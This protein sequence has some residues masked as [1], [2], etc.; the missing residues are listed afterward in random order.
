MLWKL[1]IVAILATST[2]AHLSPK[3]RITS[4]FLGYDLQYR[5]F[6]PDN[7][8][9][10]MK[11]STI[12]LTDGQLYLENGNMEKIL[13]E[14]ISSNRIEPVIAVFVD[15]RNPDNIS[16]NRRNKQFQCNHKYALFF[17]NEL[18]PT[19]EKNYNVKYN[20]NHRVIAGVSF[21]GL[22]AACFGLLI[23]NVFSGY[24]LQSPASAKHLKLIRKLYRKR[25]GLPIK[26]FLSG[27]KKKDNIKEIRRL[28]RLFLQKGYVV[29]YIEVAF[30]HNWENWGPLIDD[31]LFF[32]FD[33]PQRKYMDN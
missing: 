29:S 21:G 18:V 4:N 19:I 9:P 1:L 17:K 32:F 27:G 6:V 23:P 20:R 25:K 14:L 10:D 33:D 11:L 16:E 30:S 3:M 24:G 7:Y 28:H 13:T 31:L 22:N 8:K 2:E 15:S 26:V 12:Y 5:V